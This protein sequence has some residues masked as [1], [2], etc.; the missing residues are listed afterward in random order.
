M[1]RFFA[2]VASSLL[3]TGCHHFP[4]V[5]V[6]RS[7][8]SGQTISLSHNR[9]CAGENDPIQ[10]T[11]TPDS[12][13]TWSLNNENGQAVRT[14]TTGSG[15]T[16]D[17]KDLIEARYELAVKLDEDTALIANFEVFHCAN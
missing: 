10:V 17:T 4:R 1:T 12:A 14:G 8:L 5:V 2:L 13:L 7:A 15:F 11:F 6:T 3:F 16:L 9:V